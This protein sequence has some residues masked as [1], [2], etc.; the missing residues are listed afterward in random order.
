MQLNP[1]TARPMTTFPAGI[2]AHGTPDPDTNGDEIPVEEQPPQ[3]GGLREE[4]GILDEEDDNALPGRV[5]GGLA[6]G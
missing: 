3:Q 6:G 1:R 4:V 2:S 5:G